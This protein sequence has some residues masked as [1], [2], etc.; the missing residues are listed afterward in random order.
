MALDHKYNFDSQLDKESV[1]KN[2]R[3]NAVMAELLKPASHSLC[4]A[5]FEHRNFTLIL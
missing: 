5:R 3:C 4:Y 2:T 1:L